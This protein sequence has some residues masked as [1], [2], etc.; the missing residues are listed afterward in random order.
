MHYQ[1]PMLTLRPI[2]ATYIGDAQVTS[3]RPQHSRLPALTA[4]EAKAVVRKT[5]HQNG[6]RR[7]ASP[8]RLLIDRN[9]YF[10]DIYSRILNGDHV[11]ID[12]R[13]TTDMV[14]HL[15]DVELKVTMLFVNL[16]ITEGLDRKDDKLL[17]DIIEQTKDLRDSF[18]LFGDF[19][20]SHALKLY[21]ITDIS[22][23][24]KW[25]VKLLQQPIVNKVAQALHFQAIIAHVLN[26]NN[27]T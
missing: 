7:F 19:E 1:S 15:T 4:E 13:G 22:T 6:E 10:R 24:D 23:S 25:M 27:K 3:V 5:L 21:R 8:I 9:S 2:E 26:D 18:R 20:L 17:L 16:I 11:I 14:N 12:F